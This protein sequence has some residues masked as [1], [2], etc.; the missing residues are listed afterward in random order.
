MSFNLLKS[1]PIRR[2]IL[3]LPHGK[4]QTPFF[5][6]I[7]T[8]GAVKSLA[9]D[10]VKKLGPEIILSNTYHLLQRPGLEFLKKH[11]GLHGFMGWNKPILTDSGGFQVFSLSKYRKIT[12][13]GVTF[14]SE[15]DGRKI[16][17]SPEKVVEAQFAIGSDIMMVLD[18][19]SPWPCTHEDAE[20]GLNITLDWAR[21]SKVHFDKIV[22]RKKLTKKNRPLIFGIAQGSLYKDLRKRSIAELTKLDFDGYGI[23]GVAPKKKITEFVKWCT[24]LLPVD[25]PRYLMGVGRPEDIVEAVAVGVDM[26]DCVIPTREA[27]HG[28]LFIKTSQPKITESVKKLFYTTVRIKKEIYAHDMRPLDPHCS[29]FTCKTTT[30]SYLHHLFVTQELLFM[31][32]ASIHNLAFYLDMIRELRKK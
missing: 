31:R 25:K 24:E 8:R 4:V 27:R 6:P 19:C 2:G 20:E 1:T 13:E 26:F 21:R 28:S 7:A 15:I 16:F 23:G 3:T 22:K 9:A 11:K 29:C 17:L 18:V 14:Q 5:M 10:D 32:L 12:P 30:R